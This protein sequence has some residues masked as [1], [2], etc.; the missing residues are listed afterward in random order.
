MTSEYIIQQCIKQ[1]P[2][3]VFSKVY[4][5]F[6]KLYSSAIAN[7]MIQHL[8]LGGVYVVGG[9]TKTLLPKLVTEDILKSWKDRHPEMKELVENIP[10]VF[11]KEVD[12][13]LKG[14]FVLAKKLSK[15]NT[16]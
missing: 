11:C 13:G 8:T 15:K 14:A 1:R 3:P 12:L 10:L 4:S 6:I 9:L 2:L 7:F 16:N 5:L